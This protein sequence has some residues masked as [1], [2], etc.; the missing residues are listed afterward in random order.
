ME[1]MTQLVN[2]QMNRNEKDIVITA[3]YIDLTVKDFKTL[4]PETWLSD[5]II[6]VYMAMLSEAYRSSFTVNHSF[7]ERLSF[8]GHKSVK[9]WTKKVDLFKMSKV[10]IPVHM[11]LHWTLIVADMIRYSDV[12]ILYTPLRM[13]TPPYNFTIITKSVLVLI[14]LKSL[15]CAISNIAKKRKETSV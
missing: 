14:Y 7:F 12:L 11:P 1:E 15:E 13:K 4:K 10:L 3:H 5:E 8:G 6:T 2:Q 9:R